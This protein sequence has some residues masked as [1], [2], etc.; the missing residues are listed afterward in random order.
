M[1]QKT[2]LIIFF[3]FSSI[4]PKEKILIYAAISLTEALEEVKKI[5][6]KTNQITINYHFQA[7]GILA[8]QIKTGAPVDLFISAGEKPFSILENRII[9][10]T[11]KKILKNKLV[12][13]TIKNMMGQ[14]TSPAFLLD[15]FINKI[16][17]ANY[18]FSP[19]GDYTKKI[20]NHLS[21]WGSLKKKMIL[22]LN[23]RNVIL[24]V[25]LKNTPVG[26]CYQSDIFL[27]PSIKTIYQFKNNPKVEIAY[28]IALIQKKNIN[29]NSHAFLNFIVSKTSQNIFK[30]YGFLI[31]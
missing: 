25:K 4:F 11:K 6:E 9:K 30:K 31:P 22:T 26:I 5:Y 29:E 13:I 28:S 14:Q 20:L 24:A 2:F 18:H 10:N 16:A 27:E 7:S 8:K 17:I 3:T 19:C 12:I 15:A 21:L 1:F 23:A